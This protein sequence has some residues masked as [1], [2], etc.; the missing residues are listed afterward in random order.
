M[1]FIVERRFIVVND[2]VDA[3]KLYVILVF[4]SVNDV[5]FLFYYYV[6]NE[7]IKIRVKL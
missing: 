4:L 2:M 5:G 3:W 6:L 7:A 1:P